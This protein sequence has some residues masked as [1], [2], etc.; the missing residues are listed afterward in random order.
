MR[1]VQISF[2]LLAGEH[3]ITLLGKFEAA[4]QGMAVVLPEKAFALL[5]LLAMARGRRL[6]RGTI[7]ERLWS[8]VEPGRQAGNLRQLLLR[9][10][11]AA[12]D[13]PPLL[14]HYGDEVIAG[15]DWTFDVDVLLA[16]SPGMLAAPDVADRLI[17]G[18]DLLEG[19]RAD[20]AAFEEWLT[21]ARRR[22]SEMRIFLLT[23]ALEQLADAD[24]ATRVRLARALLRLDSTD[25]N[26]YRALMRAHADAG[27]PVKANRVYAECRSVLRDE[28]G[29]EP[30]APTRDVAEEIGRAAVVEQGGGRPA[31]KPENGAP[32][33]VILPSPALLADPLIETLG[34]GLL[35]DLTVGFS[36]Y[37]T[38]RIIAPHTSFA[39][40]GRGQP[41]DLSAGGYD[42]SIVVGARA[43]RDEFEATF[44]LTRLAE[45]EVLWASALPV[46]PRNLR[47]SMHRLV[48]RVA[49]TLATTVEQFECRLPIDQADWAPY[50]YYLEGK[51]AI[52]GTRLEELR[53]ARRWFKSAV[54]RCDNFSP[55]Y[56]GLSR[57]LTMEWLVRGMDDPELLEESVRTAQLATRFDPDSGRA[58][59]EVGFAALYRRRHD[60]ALEHFGEAYTLAP[61]DADL[62][63]DYADVLL[64]DGQTEAALSKMEEANFLNRLPP[65]YYRWIEGSIHFQREAYADAIRT[66]EKVTDKTATARLMAASLAM[67]GDEAGAR[68]Y[69]RLVRTNY[70]DFR[71]D[72]VWRIV[73]DRRPADTLQLIEGLRRAGLD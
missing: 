71:V 69:A 12:V 72:D 16:A 32:T 25:E 66:L 61:N 36:Q 38:F 24:P 2:D 31:P 55:A 50:R 11:K 15:P 4:S 40:A 29:I 39:L 42:Y 17:D 21:G 46:D 10:G 5:A 65:D 41:V 51:R 49:G 22:I 13:V 14:I 68:A 7:R 6:D 27:E 19:V 28:L 52:G 45:S 67:A 20:D 57:S 9:I 35:E 53:H 48:R 8:S 59:R 63:A 37:R 33:L 64:H 34:Y 30:S 54:R 56:A 1:P 60:E 18:G 44:R 62:L 23:R 70:P 58:H 47:E 3:R 73:P 43:A 26:G